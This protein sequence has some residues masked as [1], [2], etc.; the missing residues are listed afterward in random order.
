MYCTQDNKRSSHTKKNYNVLHFNLYIFRQN[1]V[2]YKCESHSVYH[3]TLLLIYIHNI[4]A[5]CFSYKEPSSGLYIIT[6]P[7][8]VFGV[9][10]GSQLFTLLGFCCIQCSNLVKNEVKME[11][12][13]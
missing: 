10:L 5:T 3:I 8:L 12:N 6:D 11:D 4:K 9:R 1:T 2:I 7:Y 13:V